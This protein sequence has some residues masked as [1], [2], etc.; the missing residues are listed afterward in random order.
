MSSP[1]GWSSRLQSRRARRYRGRHDL[2]TTTDNSVEVFL[3]D[4]T[5]AFSAPLRIP[6]YPAQGL[7]TADFNG[8]A[9]ADLV[10]GAPPRTWASAMATSCCGTPP[11]RLGGQGVVT[12]DFDRD[13]RPDVHT[14]SGN[15]REAVLLGDGAGGLSFATW[16]NLAP[17]IGARA[18]W[19]PVIGTAMATW[20]S[21][22]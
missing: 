9:I 15:F 12:A 19:L 2:F 8:D 14:S 22:P 1:P 11:E 17:A 5:G 21:P 7:A 6:A 3:G 20:T 16:I 10:V 18:D 4:G 13:G